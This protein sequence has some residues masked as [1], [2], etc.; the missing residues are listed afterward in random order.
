MVIRLSLLVAVLAAAIG[1]TSIAIAAPRAAD[2][3]GGGGA[4]LFCLDFAGQSVEISIERLANGLALATAKGLGFYGART[5]DGYAFATSTDANAPAGTVVLF[6]FDRTYCAY[7]LEGADID[8]EY[9]GTWT[10]GGCGEEATG[11]VPWLEPF[12]R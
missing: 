11:Q 9:C 2:P 8:S 3:L 12:E 5:Q 10:P 1:S 7:V 6:R 4:H